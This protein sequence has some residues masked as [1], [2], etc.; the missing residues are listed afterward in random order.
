[1]KPKISI[2]TPCYNAAKYIEQTILSVIN[3]GYENLEYIIIDGGSTD[4]TVDIIKKYENQLAYWI[5]E[6]DK[7]QSDAINKGIKVATG[8]VFNW[9]NAD[10]WLAADVLKIVGQYFSDAKLQVLCTQTTFINPDES[11]YTN[12][13]TKFEGDITNILNSRGLNQMGMFWKLEA[14]KKINGVNTAFNYAMDLDLWKR[15]L[16]TFGNQ[17]I[18]SDQ[19]ISGYF[20]LHAD[21]KTGVDLSVNA[22]FFDNENNAALRQY[23]AL[24][25]NK[26]LRG[27]QALYPE[28][29]EKLALVMPISVLPEENIKR[30][31]NTL[32]FT[33]ARSYFYA[34][35]FKNA[36]TLLKCIDP[37]MVAPSEIKNLKSFKR[38]SNLRRF[39]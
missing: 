32:F 17:N 15:F 38:W 27:I 23:A 34:N 18:I 37:L 6:P 4:G 9:I 16:L 35:D 14:V 3:Q 33:K 28:A 11:T 8:D 30:W 1:M 21:S 31:L 20:R 39:F 2:I 10:D 22:S 25:G 13:Y 19:I 7:G 29:D 5:S 24:I 12:V 36:Y 26:Y